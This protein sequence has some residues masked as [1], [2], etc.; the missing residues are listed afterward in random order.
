[1]RS[2]G[3]RLRLAALEARIDA[4]LALG[5]HDALTGELEHLAASHP[6]RERLHGQL[7]LALYRCGRQAEAL[8]AYRRARDLFA[9]ELGIDPG[10]PLQHL[11]QA[12]LVHDPALDWNQHRETV[13]GVRLAHVHS[14]A[15]SPEAEVLDSRPAAGRRGPGRGSRPA[16]ADQLA[17]QAQAAQLTD[18]ATA[19]TLWA[20]V[21]HIITD[22]APWVPIFNFATASFVS[23][24][25][26]NYQ[27]SFVGPL[28]DEM[29]VR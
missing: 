5:R 23:A 12:V 29:W 2:S 26:G 14:P 15:P 27:Q 7:M 21:D 28:L 22:Q 1:M 19:R 8:A 20:Q 24:R 10:E 6:L 25:V 11:H 3:P 4:D 9:A 17:S 16:H 18:P 13:A